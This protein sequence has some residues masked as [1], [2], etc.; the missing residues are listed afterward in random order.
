MKLIGQGWTI[1]WPA[2]QID[3]GISTSIAVLYSPR[4]TG[5]RWSRLPPAT[6][7]EEL[8]HRK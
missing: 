6:G 3:I 1:S 2:S 8:K 5:Q 4:D 7:L